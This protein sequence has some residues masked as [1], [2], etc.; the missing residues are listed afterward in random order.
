MP[1]AP[2][3]AVGY[4]RARSGMAL[5]KASL[6]VWKF[7]GASLA[8]A[9]AIERAASLVAGRRGP[10]VVVAS[11]LAGVTDLL[12]D[13]ARRSAAGDA[14]A[15]SEAARAFY[16]L[17]VKVARQLLP[18]NP[19]RRD[20]LLRIDAQAREYGALA[21]V[22]I[23]LKDVPARVSDLLLARGERMACALLAAALREAGRRAVVVDALE[24]VAT[25]A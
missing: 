18:D 16:K 24:L 2:A 4:P 19:A 20:L 8:D 3:R 7:G 1:A 15:A 12:L 23:A 22:L 21:R 13:G 9:P 5:T 11:A 14:R 10:L 25:D 6:E 17:H